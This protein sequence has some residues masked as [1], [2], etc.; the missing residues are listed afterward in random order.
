[1]TIAQIFFKLF[2][3]N[4]QIFRLL[5]LSLCKFETGLNFVCVCVCV[6]V[7]VLDVSGGLH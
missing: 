6:C 7:C 3:F 2:V 5:T 1:M 4:L